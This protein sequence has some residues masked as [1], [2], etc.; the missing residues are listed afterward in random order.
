MSNQGGRSK[1]WLTLYF[2]RML[3]TRLMGANGI[4]MRVTA[5][6]ARTDGGRMV[7]WPQVLSGFY[8]LSLGGR[9][10]IGPIVR[11]K[12]TLFRVSGHVVEV[13]FDGVAELIDQLPCENDLIVER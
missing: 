6:E 5:L 12:K 10:H 3:S 1:L 8:W 13:T 9:R 7:R 11:G 4:Y 2:E